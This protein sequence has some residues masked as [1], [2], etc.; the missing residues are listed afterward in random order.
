MSKVKNDAK[1]K[2]QPQAI[3]AKTKSKKALIPQSPNITRQN[4]KKHNNKGF[5]KMDFSQSSLRIYISKKNKQVIK[6]QT[7]IATE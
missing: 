1:I 6:Q 5:F 7:E 2:T 4:P 3:K